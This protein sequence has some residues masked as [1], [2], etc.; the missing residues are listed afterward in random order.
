VIV[1]NV[2]TIKTWHSRLG[3]P[4]IEMMRKI[5]GNC[6]SYD[7]KDV[8]FPKSNDFMRTSCVMG[9]LILRPSL[10][11]MHVEPLNFLERIKG[12]ICGPIKIMWTF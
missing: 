5:I 10:L 12:D 3:H 1:Q 6:T 8:K 11:K 7:L 4:G 9:K 2:D